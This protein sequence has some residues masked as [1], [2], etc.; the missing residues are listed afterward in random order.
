MEIYNVIIHLLTSASANSIIAALVHNSFKVSAAGSSGKA[1]VD[2]ESNL[3]SICFLKVEKE[4]CDSSLNQ[5]NT[6]KVFEE[7]QKILSE[8]LQV[9]YY[10]LIVVHIEH[11]VLNIGNVTVRT[12]PERPKTKAP[13]YLSLVK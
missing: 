6:R 1:C 7:I 11:I 5:Q 13:P 4:S 10:S 8:E 2:Q 9:R 3:V 12:S